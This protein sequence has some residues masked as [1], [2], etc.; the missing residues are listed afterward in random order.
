MAFCPNCGKE[1]AAEARFC[2]NCGATNSQMPANSPTMMTGP[3]PVMSTPGTQSGLQPN[4]AGVLCYAL[5]WITGLIFYFIERDRFVRFHAVQSII[6]FGAIQIA[7]MVLFRLLWAV[8]LWTI[9]GLFNTV[10][11]LAEFGLWLFLM[12]KAYNNERFKLPYA[13]DLAEKYSA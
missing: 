2:P 13:G 8:R 7:Q 3:A 6:V 9:A 1:V 5:G 11:W 4:I 12:F 10:L